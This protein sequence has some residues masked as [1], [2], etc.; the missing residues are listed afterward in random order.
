MSEYDGFKTG[1]LLVNSSH[2]TLAEIIKNITFNDY[3]HVTMAVRLDITVLPRIK[4]VRDG[5][6]MFIVEI[7]KHLKYPTIFIRQSRYRNYKVIR[8]PLRDELYTNDF[9]KQL[10]KFIKYNC[11]KIEMLDDSFVSVQPP[12]N[13]ND[14]RLRCQRCP[15]AIGTICSELIFSI[16]KYCFPTIVDDTYNPILILPR[17]F[18]Y[19]DKN[20]C[21]QLFLE[22]IQTKDQ[23]SSMHYDMLVVVLLLIILALIILFVIYL[24]MIAII[25][26]VLLVVGVIQFVSYYQSL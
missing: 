10:K 4:I 22:A 6:T 5:G 26:A 13:N 20:P 2:G 16:Y 21:R 12:D 19:D 11:V 1:D 3:N 9:V 14:F 18:V 8:Y 23:L 24:P 15:A 25:L 17:S 7:T